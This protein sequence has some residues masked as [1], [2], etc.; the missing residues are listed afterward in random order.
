M[1]PFNAPPV[2]GTEVEYMQSA[3]SSGKLCGDGG[4]TRRCQQWLEQRFGS[5]KVLLTPSCTASLEMAALLIN[6]QPGD[7][8]IMPS[9]TF[10]ST[11]NAFVLR[12]A[13]IVFVDVR[14]DTLNIDET[15]IEAAITEKTRAIVP[16]HYAGVACD[17]DAIMA[18]AR[19]YQL[20]VIEDAAQGVMSTYKG[21]ALGSIGHIGCFSF[22]ETK[23]YTAGG[24]GGATLINDSALVERAE[25]I[26]EKGTNRSQFFRGQVDKYTWRDIGSS[27][28]MSDLQAAY[29]WAQL[30]AATRINQQRLHLWQRYHDALKP[31]A[32]RGRI[33][34]P[35]IPSDCEHNAHMFYIKLRDADDRAALINWLKEAEILA[36]F[37]YIPL[38]SSPAGEQFGRFAGEDR[39]TTVESERLLRLP[40]FYNL[41]DNNQSTV[42]N[43]LLSFFS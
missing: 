41:S 8:V 19:K 7:E 32:A 10:V 14:P 13:K 18:L 42:I 11:A 20:Y 23:N 3:M 17:M 34:L 33:E 28:L 26:R 27:Y 30:E 40:L 31:V 12:G 25:I 35:G 36:V 15:R 16:V 1:I 38:H 9:Y 21:R 29:L 2:V 5:K 37:H 24:E 43:S 4:F 39:Y 22:H 6:I